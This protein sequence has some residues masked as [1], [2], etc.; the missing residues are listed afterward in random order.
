MCCLVQRVCFQANKGFPDNKV[1][2]QELQSKPELKKYL[3]KLMPFVQ[4][5]K[6][7]SVAGLMDVHF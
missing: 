4:V 2:S 7:S 5:A 3:K 1:I 6:V